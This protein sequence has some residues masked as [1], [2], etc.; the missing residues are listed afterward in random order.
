MV[1]TDGGVFNFGG[2]FAGST[3]ARAGAPPVVGIAA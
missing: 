1:A 3:T 2:A